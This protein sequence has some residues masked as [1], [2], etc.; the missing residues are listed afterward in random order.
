MNLL[1]RAVADAFGSEFSSRST[2]SLQTDLTAL[3]HQVQMGD[4]PNSLT[5]LNEEQSVQTDRVQ[6]GYGRPNK[7]TV[8]RTIARSLWRGM[9]AASA[10][11]G[12]RQS[13]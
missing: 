2:L 11:D 10:Q 4:G 7:T 12:E 1:D 6:I 3:L 13:G 5:A 8:L 9:T